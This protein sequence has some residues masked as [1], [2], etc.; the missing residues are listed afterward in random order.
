MDRSKP[1]K[2]LF[3]ILKILVSGGLIYF[4]FSRIGLSDV[5]SNISKINPLYFIVAVAIYLSQLFISTNRW[6]LLIERPLSLKRLYSLY[7][8]GSFF[9]IFLPGIVGGDTVKAY[10]LNKM[11]KSSLPNGEAQGST[12]VTAI[13]S[14][15]MDRY[16]GFVAMLIMV[17]AVYPFS[18][19]YL[20][21]T[22][23]IWLLPL[24]FAMFIIVSYLMLQ[25]RIGQ[26]F[27]F[28][29]NLY[30]YFSLYI[31]K[32]A[33]ILKTLLLSVL[34]QTAGIT[35]V[36]I[37]SMGLSM[38]VPFITVLVFLP[39]IILVSF[40]PISIAGIG[41]REGAFVFFFSIISVPSEQSLTLSIIWFLSTCAASILGLV[42]YLRI[43]GDEKTTI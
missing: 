27:G 38:D 12:L 35:A 13:A 15:F 9:G 10:Y 36:Y 31:G 7:L 20:K 37:L 11:L 42:E 33:V 25:F 30:G 18:V 21:G 39:I 5:L 22:V 1:T 28:I 41:L 34:T 4:L 32:K 24:L 29:A 17:I 43:R 8:I 23:F 19:M 26:R 40:I 14:V 3:L 16:L 2:V 6:S